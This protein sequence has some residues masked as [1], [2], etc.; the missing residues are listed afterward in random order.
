MTSGPG[1]YPEARL[2]PPRGEWA[3]RFEELAAELQQRLG[4]RWE[5]EHVGSTSIHGLAA[6]PVIDLAL[7]IPAGSEPSDAAVH[8]AR[9]GWSEPQPLR[10]HWVTFLLD[11]DVRVGIAH[12]FSVEQWRHAHVRLFAQWLRT[13]PCDAKR[14][15]QL[16]QSLINDGR[17]GD[18]YTSGKA[19]FVREIVDLATRS[20]A[21]K[22]GSPQ[23]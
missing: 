12:L 19:A 21:D 10:G 8:L 6:K 14:Y 17:W 9:A 7:R 2:F 3:S 4:P 11:G 23:Q 16:K 22:V 15:V 18:G 13:H 20:A 1:R 5:I